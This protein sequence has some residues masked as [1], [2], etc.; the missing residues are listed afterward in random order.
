M[1]R[2]LAMALTLML[3]LSLCV[4]FATAEGQTIKGWGAFNFNDQTGITSYSQ[5][6]LW[7]EVAS[8]LGITVEWETVSENEKT[9]LFSLM[10]ADAANLPDMVVDMSPLYYDCLLYTSPSPRDA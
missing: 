8:R 10:M 4:G 5:Q 6:Y 1:K 3:A 7:Q 9:T 2:I